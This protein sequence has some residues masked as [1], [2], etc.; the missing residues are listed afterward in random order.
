MTHEPEAPESVENP[1]VQFL[2]DEEKRVVEMA[3]SEFSDG[4]LIDFPEDKVQERVD[5]TEMALAREEPAIFQATFLEEG[6]AVSVDILARKGRGHS[7]IEV[8]SDTSIRPHHLWE[9]AVQ[10]FVLRRAGVDVDSVEIMHLNEK[11]RFP[12]LDDLFVTES[13]SGRVRGLYPQISEIISKQISVLGGSL[14]DVEVGD[15]CDKPTS[16]PFKGRCWP[17]LPKHHV[18]TF[19]GLRKEKSAQLET[20]ALTKVE[21]VPSTFPLTLIQQRQQRSVLEGELQ[22]EDGLEGALAPFKGR[23]AY[24]DFQTVPLSIPVWV[25]LGPWQKHPVQFGCQIALPNGDVK[26]HEWLAE[27]PDDSRA[28][29]AQ[30]LLETL[31]GVDVV[32]AYDKGAQ[33]TCLEAISAAVPEQAREIMAISSKTVDLLPIVRD[34]VYHPDFLGSFSLT[35]VLP[36]LVPSLGYES[37]EVSAGQSAEALLHSL[38]F[39]GNSQGPDELKTLRHKLQSACAS[40][41]LA[42]VR[43]KERLDELAGSQS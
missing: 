9:V 29:M 25:G 13:I 40:D 10:A 36:P 26:H 1:S 22:V 43:L 4:F 5:A 6:V 12:G 21:D 37:L 16:C 34:N 8:K 41:T 31:E 19:Y 20:L 23:V 39:S 42:L 17:A 3:R 11:C 33:K 2:Q 28:V 27:G 15:H 7:L 38:L 24:L 18:E 32:V 30:A 35:S 14:P